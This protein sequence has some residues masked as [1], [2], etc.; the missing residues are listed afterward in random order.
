MIFQ[1]N[2]DSFTTSVGITDS[3]EKFKPFVTANN[4]LSP[5]VRCIN[6]SRISVEFKGTCLKQDKITFTTRNVVNLFIAYKLDTWSKYLKLIL[7]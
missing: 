4:S 1:E 7:L 3:N 6:N 2:L 5:K